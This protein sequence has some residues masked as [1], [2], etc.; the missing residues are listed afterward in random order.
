MDLNVTSINV[1]LSVDGVWF[2][3]TPDISFKVARDG[4]PAHE[5]ALQSHIKRYR[6]MDE[7]GEA[8]QI[9]QARNE[10]I[11]KYILKDWKGLK[12]NGKPL[13]FSEDVALAILSDPQYETIKTFV[14]ECSLDDAE[15]EDDAEETIK[16]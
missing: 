15:F 5:R 7:K 10:M 3:L 9:K 6:K 8:R 4:N 13:K 11:A 1:D 14:V 2:N 12:D 16:N